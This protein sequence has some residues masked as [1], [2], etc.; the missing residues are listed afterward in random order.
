MNQMRGEDANRLDDA[1]TVAAGLTSVTSTAIPNDMDKESDKT[2]FNEMDMH[3]TPPTQKC[4][5]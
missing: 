3:R 1:I 2:Q 5:V 4:R